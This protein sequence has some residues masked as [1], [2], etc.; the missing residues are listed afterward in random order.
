MKKI[1]TLFAF[2]GALLFT[3]CGT[4]EVFYTDVVELAGEW[5]VTVDEVDASGNVLEEDLVG[6]INLLTY[7]TVANTN[8]MWIDDL[9]KFWSTKVKVQV[10]LENSTFSCNGY[11][12]EY[13]KGTE[14]EYQATITDGRINYDGTKSPLGHVVDEIVFTIQF[15]DAPGEYYRFHGYRRTGFNQGAD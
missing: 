11:T 2:V 3:S 5:K 8:E 13:C 14:Y 1:L 4:E 12:D 15:S 9:K 7:N 6:T 10:N